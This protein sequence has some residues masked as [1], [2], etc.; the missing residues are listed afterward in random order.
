VA[1]PLL[2]WVIVRWT[3]AARRG[4]AVNSSVQL[5]LLFMDARLDTHSAAAIRSSHQ[6]AGSAR[7]WIIIEAEPRQLTVL[8]LYFRCTF[9]DDRDVR[10]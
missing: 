1:L 8:L 7:T 3:R 4:G 5:S 9:R 6:L 2:N 10:Q